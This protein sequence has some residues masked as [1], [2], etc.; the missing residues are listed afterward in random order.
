MYK[1]QALNDCPFYYANIYVGQ[2]LHIT[3]I[4]FICFNNKNSSTKSKNLSSQNA[5]SI[6]WRQIPKRKELLK[7]HIPITV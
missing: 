6:M 7:C 4:F 3:K 5:C 1:K 2:L